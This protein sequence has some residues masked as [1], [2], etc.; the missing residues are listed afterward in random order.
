MKENFDENP[1]KIESL[2]ENSDIAI[3]PENGLAIVVI[4]PDAFRNRDRIHSILERQGLYIERTVERKLPIDFVLGQMY[5]D[6]P[7]SI[8]DATGEH[9]ASGE[10]EIIL[11]KGGPDLGEKIVK[12]TG[13]DTDPAK[14]DKDTIRFLFGEHFPR[15]AGD[16]QYFRNAAHRGKNPEER[17]DDLKKFEGFF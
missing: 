1:P 6:L 10:S 12:I 17:R 9:F 14:C 8:K 2:I 13:V 16:R 5:P 11:V 3:D 15:P 4:K 7:E